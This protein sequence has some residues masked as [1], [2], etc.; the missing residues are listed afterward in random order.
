LGAGSAQTRP[1]SLAGLRKRGEVKRKGR[2]K[3]KEGKGKEGKGGEEEGRE[4]AIP[5]R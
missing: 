4:Y 2:G 3:R 1:D 5:L